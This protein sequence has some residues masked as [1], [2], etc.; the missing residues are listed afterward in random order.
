MARRISKEAS[1]KA[2]LRA[3][4]VVFLPVV[5]LCMCLL[6]KAQMWRLDRLRLEAKSKPVKPSQYKKDDGALTK[7]YALFKFM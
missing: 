7:K 3:K 2:K 1:E 5:L 4:F 6:V